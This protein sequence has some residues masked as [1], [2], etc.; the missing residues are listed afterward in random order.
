MST[1]TAA[2]SGIRRIWRGVGA[3][4]RWMKR[5]AGGPSGATKINYGT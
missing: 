3:T 4:L 5:N 1:R 2:L